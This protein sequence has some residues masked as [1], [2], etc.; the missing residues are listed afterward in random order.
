MDYFGLVISTL[1]IIVVIFAIM[2]HINKSKQDIVEEL[3]TS[4][5]ASRYSHSSKPDDPSFGTVSA[6]KSIVDELKHYDAN[7]K[8]SDENTKQ[9]P[10]DGSMGGMDGGM[11]NLDGLDGGGSGPTHSGFRIYRESAT[12]FTDLSGG[13][14]DGSLGPEGG[15]GPDRSAYINGGGPIKDLPDNTLGV[16]PIFA[17]NKYGQSIHGEKIQNHESNADPYKPFTYYYLENDNINQP[18]KSD[19]DCK[20]SKCSESGYCR[21]Q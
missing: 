21:Y 10:I 1:L 3:F 19:A 16:V 15:F 17:E 13:K 4:Y 2:D 20:T 7:P 12:P 9:E 8:Y 14:P 18:C 11:A 5:V 6:Q